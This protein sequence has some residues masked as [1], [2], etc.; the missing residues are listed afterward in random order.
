MAA[1]ASELVVLE[2]VADGRLYPVQSGD[3]RWFVDISSGE[4]DCPAFWFQSAE[5]RR[6]CKHA[7]A[8]AQHLKDAAACP[9]CH[10]QGALVPGPQ[11]NY[12]LPDGTRDTGSAACVMCQGSGK[13]DVSVDDKREESRR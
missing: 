11:M 9:Y 10:G 5:N 3:H 12:V 8:V 1:A 2:P 4:C 6:L 7:R 13:R